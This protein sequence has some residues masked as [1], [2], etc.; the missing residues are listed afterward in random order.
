MSL[1]GNWNGAE[2]LG[3]QLPEAEG[4]GHRRY[5]KAWEL[6]K[7]GVPVMSPNGWPDPALTDAALD[8]MLAAEMGR[9]AKL[10]QAFVRAGSATIFRALGVQILA[11]D[12]SVYT[13]GNHDPLAQTNSSRPLGLLAGAE[14]MVTDGLQVRSHGRAMFLPLALTALSV[15]TTA[16]AAVVF[17]DGTVHARALHGNHE[18]CK[19]QKQAARFNAL[20]G[21]AAPGTTEMDAGHVTKLQNLQELWEAGLLSQQEY[22]TRRAEIIAS[23]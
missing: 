5:A 9:R 19:A 12:D 1:R 6:H 16:D 7:L 3:H 23:F 13:I 14:A 18:I 20:A 8:G 4:A 22:D 11:G 10:Y 2:K 21:A 15:K 17:P